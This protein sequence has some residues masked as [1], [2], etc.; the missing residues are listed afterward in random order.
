MLF[1]GVHA[2]IKILIPQPRFAS[3]CK[4]SMEV[5]YPTVTW[6][7]A[8]GKLTCPQKAVGLKETITKELAKSRIVFCDIMKV[9]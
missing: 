7:K 2:K 3:P 6:R 5:T 9:N 1:S 4:S 8:P